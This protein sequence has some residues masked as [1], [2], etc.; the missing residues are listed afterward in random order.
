ISC[1]G[2]I[3]TV[4]PRDSDWVATALGR[5]TL[6]PDSIIAELVIMKMIS[7][8]RKISVSGVMLISATMSELSSLPPS[9]VIAMIFLDAHGLDDLADLDAKQ[10]VDGRD[11]GLKIIVE[12]DRDDRHAEAERGRHQRFGNTGGDHRKAAGA[13]DRHAFEGF[14]DAHHRA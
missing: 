12:D 7:S 8:T 2:V 11:A 1:L 3:V 4:M 6:P 10:T 5:L 14:D 13:G 9:G